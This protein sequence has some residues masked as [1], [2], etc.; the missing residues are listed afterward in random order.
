MAVLNGPDFVVEVANDKALQ[1]WDRRVA[2]PFLGKPLFTIIPET[3]ARGL[4][5][6]LQRVYQTGEG[7]F[8]PEYPAKITRRGKDENIYVGFAAEALREMDGYHYWR[9]DGCQ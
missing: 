8:T 2:G 9:N 3:N 7:F 5:Q 1:F 6:I 4:K